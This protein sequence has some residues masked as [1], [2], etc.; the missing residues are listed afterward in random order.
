MS[1]RGHALTHEAE[2]ALQRLAELQ[3][4]SADGAPPP[5]VDEVLE[6]LSVALHELQVG[7]EELREQN[8]RLLHAESRL[9]EERRRY[10]ELFEF[11]PD[12]Y[13]VTTAT[14][15]IREANR[16]AATLFGVGTGNLLGKPLSVFIHI[17]DRPA[18]RTLI[19]RM[20]AGEMTTQT[21]ETSIVPRGAV[22]FRAVL[23][24]TAA[25]SPRTANVELR[26]TLRD[27][28]VERAVQQDLLAE[29]EERKRAEESL[30][31][32]EL[33][34]RH[35]VEHATDIVYELDGKG[36]FTFCNGRATHRILGY[37]ERELIG[38][39][40]I[41]LV[42]RAHQKAVRAFANRQLR[43]PGKE[44]YFEFPVRAKDNR[45]VWLG[46]HASPMLHGKELRIQAI[47]RDVSAISMNS[48]ANRMTL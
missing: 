34:Y 28:S 33:R 10:Q 45:I 42:P 9:S 40:L 15:V 11:G 23:R 31:R 32:S 38:R 7:S 13:L 27:V 48:R 24:V 22:P 21:L 12:G 47:C 43:Q 4:R 37:T 41:D 5:D 30:R 14:A 18:F 20:A 2:L 8:E 3:L 35:L 19:N 29:I 6:E 46:Q 25:R 16:M 26:W 1:D 39:R 36:R 17:D 44:N